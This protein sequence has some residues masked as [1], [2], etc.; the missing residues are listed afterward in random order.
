MVI[1]DSVEAR[2]AAQ[3]KEHPLLSFEELFDLERTRLYQALCLMTADRQEAEDLAQDAFVRVYERWE[4]VGS[5]EDPVGYLYRT[6]LNAYRSHYRRSLR[7]L[8]RQM[9]PT[10]RPDAI[11]GAEQHLELM[12]RLARLTTKQ[13][14]AVVLLDLLELSSDEAGALMGMRPGAVRT[15]ASRARAELRR[16]AGDDD[17]A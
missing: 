8:R 9:P 2:R 6:A 4:R 14:A 11:S 16:M 5:L 12:H 10:E 13:R 17:D 3:D 1:E 15:Q 7:A